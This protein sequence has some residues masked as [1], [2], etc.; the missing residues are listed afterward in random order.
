MRTIPATGLAL[1]VML[2]MGVALADDKA[3]DK[4]WTL[5]E[6]DQAAILIH[7]CTRESPIAI[8]DVWLPEAPA[9]RE[10]NTHLSEI[11]KLQSTLCCGAGERLTDIGHYRLQ[12]AGLIIEGRKLI[13]VNALP[14]GSAYPDWRHKAV[15]SCDTSRDYWGVLYDPLTGDFSDLAFNGKPDADAH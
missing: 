5:L 13:Y 10:L 15:L 2:L 14:V 12:Y 9:L 8:Q 6:G 11:T 4:P 7:Q 1:A 3:A